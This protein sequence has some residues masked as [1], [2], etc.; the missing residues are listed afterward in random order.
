M[1][2]VLTALNTGHDGGWA[3]IHANGAREVPARL[4]ALGA[5]AGMGEG[6]VAAQASSALDAVLHMRRDTDGHRWVSEVGVLT[7]ARGPLE[8]VLALSSTSDGC[9]TTHEAWAALARRVG[10]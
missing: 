3:T 5:L 4:V 6:A 2:D 8:C 10:L 1:R 7:C 9:I